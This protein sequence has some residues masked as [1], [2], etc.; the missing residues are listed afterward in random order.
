M[1][2]CSP[3]QPTA[4][5]TQTGGLHTTISPLELQPPGPQSVTCDRAMPLVLQLKTSPS[6]HRYLLAA[7]MTSWHAPASHA[8][9]VAA[10]SWPPGTAEP[11]AAQDVSRLPSQIAAPGVLHTSNRQLGVPG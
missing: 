8:W 6:Q 7:Q 4:L 11:S 9:S 5:A 10:Q 2:T 3:S 1:A